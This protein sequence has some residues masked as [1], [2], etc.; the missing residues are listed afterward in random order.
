L[1]NKA[2]TLIELLA[3]IVILAIIALIAVPIILNIIDDS[4]KSGDKRSIELYAQALKNAI[5]NYQVKNPQ[6][7]DITLEKIKDD[8][9][10]KGNKVECNITQINKDG[11]IYL[12]DC[13][14]NG[15]QVEYTYGKEQKEENKIIGKAATMENKTLSGIVPTGNFEPGDEYIINVDG[16]NE[17][18]FYV[19]NAKEDKVSLMMSNNI[20][21]DGTVATTSQPCTVNWVTSEDTKDL[22]DGNSIDSSIH[23]PITAMNY[24][25]ETT[26][27]WSNIPNINIDYSDGCCYSGVKTIG[28]RT[29]ITMN[30]GTET[31]SYENLKSRLF[32]LDDLIYDEN[33]RL[34]PYFTNGLTS[35]PEL[36]PE[37]TKEDIDGIDG[38]W[39]FN[40]DI[41]PSAYRDFCN[42]NKY[43]YYNGVVGSNGG[44][45]GVRPIIEIPKSSLN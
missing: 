21:K 2:F 3:V 45:I 23:G 39:T 11:T 10:Y 8:I 14:I 5:G 25:Y 31:T 24:L 41:N 1:K 22:P 28:S 36:Y 4:K 44:Y 27:N 15:K 13:K 33:N 17:Y 6:D 38:Y 20:C 43:V 40:S 32:S 9:E 16:T 37:G 19:L 42:L 26:K 34:L 7:K 29:V 18:H 35:Y 12:S 30:D